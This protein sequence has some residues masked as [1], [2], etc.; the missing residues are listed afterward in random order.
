ML[1]CGGLVGLTLTAGA[2]VTLPGESVLV[3]P[4]FNFLVLTCGTYIANYIDRSLAV[5]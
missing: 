3:I 2:S 5:A 1:H 4:H